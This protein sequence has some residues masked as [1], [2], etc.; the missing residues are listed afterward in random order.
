MNKSTSLK[1][2]SD[3][4]SVETGS[5]DWKLNKSTESKYSFEYLER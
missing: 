2:S 4:L 5:V 1:L 3:T